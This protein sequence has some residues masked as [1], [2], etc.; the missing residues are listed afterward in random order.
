MFQP[1]CDIPQLCFTV[2]WRQ[3][4]VFSYDIKCCN[5]VFEV[6]ALLNT[7]KKYFAFCISTLYIRLQN[8]LSVILCGN[9]VM[10]Q[11]SRLWGWR[12]PEH[13]RFKTSAVV[14]TRLAFFCDV[15]W[16]KW[17]VLGQPISL[18][19]ITGQ[20]VLEYGT[21]RLSRNVGKELPTYAA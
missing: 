8:L 21:N 5:T 19:V 1:L 9:A 2:H 13:E 16:H 18:H 6:G 4:T 11:W 15:T 10:S 7:H 17:D 12:R 14:Q 3:L 20:T